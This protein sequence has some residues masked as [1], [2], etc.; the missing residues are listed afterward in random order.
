MKKIYEEAV[1]QSGPITL[2][3]ANDKQDT[4]KIE[5]NELPLIQQSVEKSVKITGTDEIQERALKFILPKRDPE[6]P[7]IV[8]QQQILKS[9]PKLSLAKNIPMDKKCFEPIIFDFDDMSITKGQNK[10]HQGPAIKDDVNKD[11]QIINDWFSQYREAQFTGDKESAIR[12]FEILL[13]FAMASPFLSALNHNSAKET[14]QAYLYPIFAV[15]FGPS[16]GGKT[17]F[18][19]MLKPLTMRSAVETRGIKFTPLSLEKYQI[20][21]AMG[22][23]TLDDIALKSVQN[24]LDAIV[25]KD[26]VAQSSLLA[27]CILTTNKDVYSLE[28]SVLKRVLPIWI[29]ATTEVKNAKRRP[30]IGLGLFRSFLESAHPIYERHLNDSPNE[31]FLNEVSALWGE[32]DLDIKPI[33]SEELTHRATVPI[34]RKLE[35]LLEEKRK[36]GKLTFTTKEVAITFDDANE[37]KSLM[38]DLPMSF[39][40]RLGENTLLIKIDSVI[41]LGID[42]GFVQKLKRM[43]LR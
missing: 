10:I 30:K 42:L 13:T 21:S 24:H 22:L 8:T 34:K 6:K 43:I 1:A 23:I 26:E 40:P 16:S 36:N 28:A 38:A 5:P 29:D 25:K 39:Q 3:H 31:R 18:V 37:A 15:M 14:G 17:S 12:G 20:S 27:P 2:K 35:T 33:T 32:F 11:I 9:I 41:A 4:D 7:R 19:Q